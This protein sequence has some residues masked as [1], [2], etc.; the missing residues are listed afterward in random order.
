MSDSLTFYSKPDCPL[1]DDAFPG[2]SQI[3]AK[4]GV[5]IER[6]NIEAAPAVFEKSRYRIPGVTFRGFELGWGRF[7]VEEIAARLKADLEK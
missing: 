5:E 7:T 2:V 1:C 3:A 4:Y 6:V